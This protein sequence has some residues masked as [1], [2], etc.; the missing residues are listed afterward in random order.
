[1]AE[2]H[3]VYRINDDGWH[4]S[5]RKNPD[6]E[7]IRLYAANGE[8]TD[9]EMALAHRIA[10]VDDLL[11]A[12]KLAFEEFDNMFIISGSDRDCAMTK[13]EIAIAKAEGKS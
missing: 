10:A 12:C 6:K 8:I 2:V 11:E 3:G 5:I 7:Y 1:M 13:L 4:I 9:E